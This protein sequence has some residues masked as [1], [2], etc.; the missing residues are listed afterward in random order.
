[1]SRKKLSLFA[2]VLSVSVLSSCSGLS[3]APGGGGTG[4][5]GSGNSGV[6][7][8][9]ITMISEAQSSQASFTILAFSAQITSLT[10]NVAGGNAMPLTLSP[11]PYPVDFNRLTTDTALFGTFSVPADT[12]FGSM[13]MALSN[14]TLTIANNGATAIGTCAAGAVCEFTFA[15]QN[16]TI[17]ASEFSAKYTSGS[18]NT[19]YFSVRPDNIVTLTNANLVVD[20][21]QTNFVPSLLLPRVG[22]APNTIDTLEDFTGVVAAVSATSI[23]VVSGNK[24]GITATLAGTTAFDDQ[25]SCN[26]VTASIANCVKVGSIV[27]LDGSVSATGVLTASEIDLIDPATVD[28][29]EGTIFA[30]SPGNFALVVTDKQEA[31]NGLAGVAQANIGDIFTVNGLATALFSVDTKT[32]N[33][34]R[35]GYRPFLCRHKNPHHRNTHRSHQ[36]FPGNRGHS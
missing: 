4:G 10:L 3:D 26:A 15:P 34:Q 8:L 12:T 33:C 16:A 25:T 5:G 6:A 19:I 32:L 7:N 22:A 21:T 20:F 9:T 24:V 30:T 28:A 36:S 27:S 23:S 2:L 29:I 14:I 35:S 31:T 13:T 17:A 1:M 11:S 18:N